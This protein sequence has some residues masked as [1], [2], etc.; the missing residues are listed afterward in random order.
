MWIGISSPYRK[1]G[2]LFTKWRDHFAQNSDEV[3]IVQGGSAA[4]NPTLDPAMIA[5]ASAA[6]PEAAGAEWEGTFRTDLS[7][8]LDDATIDAAVDLSRPLELPPRQKDFTY[9][10][11][12]DASGGRRDAFTVCVA[13]K[14]GDR[15]IADVVRGREPPFDPVDVVSEYSALIK[16]YGLSSITGDNYSAE[17]VVASFKD[18]GIEYKRSELNKSALYLEALPLFARGVV[19]IPNDPRLIRELRMLERRASRTGRDVVNHPANGGSDDRSNSLVG[20]LRNLA[21][22]PYMYDSTLSWVDD[23]DDQASSERWRASL[24]HQHLLRR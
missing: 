21:A 5:R 19:G 14:E 18:C 12:A 15:Y 24:Y 8:F 6:D 2:L 9:T 11:F 4:F 20:A 13:H 3:L 7:N 16:E 22:P 23:F 17:W 1:I 10:A